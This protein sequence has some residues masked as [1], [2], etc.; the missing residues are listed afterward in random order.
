MR[1]DGDFATHHRDGNQVVKCLDTGHSAT[2]RFVE[3]FATVGRIGVEEYITTLRDKGVQ[4]P[5]GLQVVS[6]KP[7]A[8]RHDWVEGP[9]LLSAADAAPESFIDAV[10]Q[11]GQW[12]RAVDRA[13]ARIDT[14]LANFCLVDGQPVLVDVLPPLFVSRRPQPAN[15]FEALFSGLCF[16]TEVTLAALVGYAARAVLRGAAGSAQVARFV[17]VARELSSPLDAAV[18][19]SLTEMWFRSR[20]TVGLRALC[21]DLPAGV[22][23][24]FFYLTSVRAFRDL[25]EPLRV[26]RVEQVRETF[27]RLRDEY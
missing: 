22:M 7:L 5:P 14:N 24:G 11:I 10:T 27:R 6:E 13:D 8:V 21:G 15:L 12:A 26:R 18:D 3:A 4:L 16:D 25:D 9:D 1:N 20:A 17:S 19:G 23:H 2:A